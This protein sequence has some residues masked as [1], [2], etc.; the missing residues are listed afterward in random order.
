MTPIESVTLLI[1]AAN[2]LLSFKG[3]NDYSFFER[4]KFNVGKIAHGEKDR[5]LSSAF[6]HVDITHLIFNM[7]TLYFFA[8]IV[9]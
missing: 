2:V 4:Y 1:I 6:L 3:F 7:L 5:L 8:P 9:I